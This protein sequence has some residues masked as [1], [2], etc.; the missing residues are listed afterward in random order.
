VYYSR[1]GAA[2]QI[3]ISV[4]KIE[5]TMAAKMRAPVLFLLF[6]SFKLS[7]SWTQTG[8]KLASKKSVPDNVRILILPGFGNESNDYL[9]E[10]APQGSLVGSLKKCGWKDEQ[11]RVL[12]LERSDWLQVFLRGAVNLDFWLSKAP[13][14]IAFGWYLDR[15]AEQIKELTVDKEDSKVVLVCHSAGGWLARAA[16]GFGGTRDTI[17]S[18]SDEDDAQEK[19]VSFG[20]DLDRVLGMVTLGAPHTP[21]P[22]EVMDMTRGALRITHEEFP[23]AFHAPSLFYITV[24]GNA[25]TGV[26]QMRKTP[27]E[28]TSATGF[29]FNS[30]EAVCGNGTAVGDGVVPV[31]AGHVDSAMQIELPGVFHSINAP[32]SWYGSDS[33]I[34][35]WHDTMMDQ[36][37][38]MNYQRQQGPSRV[39]PF[40]RFF[41]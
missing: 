14:K 24:I 8:R 13:P 22:P 29:A 30:Y 36:I 20:I 11:I 12:P 41:Q 31:V 27:F 3:S 40:E 37:N 34:N 15:V 28:P 5:L 4:L 25:I 7:F 38:K 21:P 2:I 26:K 39:S 16:L 10:Q 6:C 18:S 9:L 1:V 32:D 35:T 33:I 17:S 19:G 23:G